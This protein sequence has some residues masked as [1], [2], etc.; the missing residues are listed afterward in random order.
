M[1]RARQ[2]V[3]IAAAQLRSYLETRESLEVEETSGNLEMSKYLGMTGY[4]AASG[5][6]RVVTF[7]T[8]PMWK[9]DSSSGDGASC[10]ET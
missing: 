6:A 1:I 7:H 5:A 8:R 4:I 9:G 10:Y 2:A 3:Q